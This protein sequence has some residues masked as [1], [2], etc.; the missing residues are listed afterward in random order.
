MGFIE[1]IS[2]NKAHH[3][4]YGF[5]IYAHYFKTMQIKKILEQYSSSCS[6]QFEGKRFPEVL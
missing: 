3:I 5:N 1:N 6:L 2:P 4:L